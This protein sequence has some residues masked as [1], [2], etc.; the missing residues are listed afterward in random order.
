MKDGVLFVGGGYACFPTT[1]MFWHP[2]LWDLHSPDEQE[3]NN[4]TCLMTLSISGQHKL[5][6]VHMTVVVKDTSHRD[7]GWPFQNVCRQGGQKTDLKHIG[8]GDTYKRIRSL[9]PNLTSW[10]VGV[11]L[12]YLMEVTY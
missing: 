6:H 3:P 11:F 1:S 8:F 2:Y 10:E 7:R 4:P 12:N 9:Y 5:K